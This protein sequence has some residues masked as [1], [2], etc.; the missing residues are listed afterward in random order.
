[1]TTIIKKNDI[2]GIDDVF[3]MIAFCMIRWII[4]IIFFSNFGYVLCAFSNEQA[5]LVYFH[6]SFSSIC[7]SLIIQMLFSNAILREA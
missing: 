6:F 4:I 7:S 5:I 3:F 1:M 2:V